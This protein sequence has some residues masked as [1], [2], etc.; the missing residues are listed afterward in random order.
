MITC[1]IWF[2][3]YRIYTTPCGVLPYIY[4][5]PWGIA[6]YIRLPVGNNFRVVAH[7]GGVPRHD[8]L[9]YMVQGLGFIV[10]I[11][12]PVGY[13][14]TYTTPHGELP[15]IYTTPRGEQLSGSHPSWGG[16]PS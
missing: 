16:P 8:H 11:R 4:D 9:S 14:H 6:I 15:Y 2:R 3:I 13:C 1:H 7:L 12:L 10:Y 5:T